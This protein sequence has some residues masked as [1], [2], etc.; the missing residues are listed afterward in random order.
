[1]KY[2]INFWVNFQKWIRTI[3]SFVLF[4]IILV[5][6]AD[7]KI[8]L[9]NNYELTNNKMYLIVLFIVMILYWNYR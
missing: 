6:Y 9:R 4:F 3:S 7:A 8:I 5:L 1:M 2:N